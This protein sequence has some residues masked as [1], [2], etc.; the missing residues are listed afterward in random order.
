LLYGTGGS[1][2]GG[3]EVSGSGAAN[4][5]LT[6]C[7]AGI[8]C[9]PTGSASGAFAFSQSTTRTGWTLGGGIEGTITGRWTWK[10]EYLYLDLGSE[11][12][13]VA[14]NFGGI[15]SWNAKFTDNIVRVGLNYKFGS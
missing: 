11:S 9:I 13:T 3:V 12:G 14:D 15:A 2:S 8:G 7:I 10:A 4:I 5:N 6:A 1:A